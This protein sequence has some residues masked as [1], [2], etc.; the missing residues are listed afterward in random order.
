[1]K[2]YKEEATKLQ[3]RKAKAAI[4]MRALH[5]L[6]EIARPSDSFLFYQDVEKETEQAT[7]VKLEIFIA[8]KTRPIYHS[9]KKWA[10]RA[11]VGSNRS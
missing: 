4:S 2:K 6:K 5:D 1:M 11:K 7:V 3:K 9:V 10:E 8:M